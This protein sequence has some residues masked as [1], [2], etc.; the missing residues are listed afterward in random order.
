MI[1]FAILLYVVINANVAAQG[2]GFVWLGIG[3][4][5]LVVL[6]RHRPPA[7]TWPG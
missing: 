6:L 7:A 4:V 3:V 1:G 2:L 5:V